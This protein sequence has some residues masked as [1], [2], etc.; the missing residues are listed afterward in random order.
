MLCL[1]IIPTPC[2]VYQ[3]LPLIVLTGKGGIIVQTSKVGVELGYGRTDIARVLSD[4]MDRY[5]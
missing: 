2:T 5:W 3:F 1:W 4:A